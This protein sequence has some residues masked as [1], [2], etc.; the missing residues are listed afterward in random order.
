MLLA[1]VVIGLLSPTLGRWLV[2]HRI[3]ELVSAG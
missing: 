2:S 3:Y 1:L